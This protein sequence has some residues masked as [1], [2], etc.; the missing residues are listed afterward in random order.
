VPTIVRAFIRSL[1][2]VVPEYLTTQG[3]ILGL[4]FALVGTTLH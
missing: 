1:S 4:I 2:D 3:I